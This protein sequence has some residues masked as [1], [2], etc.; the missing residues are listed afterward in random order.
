MKQVHNLG[1]LPKSVAT[2][3]LIEGSMNAAAKAKGGKLDL[4]MAWI[5][6][7]ESSMPVIIDANSIEEIDI[8]LEGMLKSDIVEQTL[9]DKE[10][11]REFHVAIT[12]CGSTKLK[13]D[14]PD[15]FG[16]V[17]TG[18]E[19]M[20]DGMII[21]CEINKHKTRTTVTTKEEEHAR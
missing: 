12:L 13:L 21:F 14:G 16:E 3:A 18:A 2:L 7:V 10:T 9:V 5:E 19:T 20:A 1:N 11:G 8:A 15:E 6:A 4:N 17:G